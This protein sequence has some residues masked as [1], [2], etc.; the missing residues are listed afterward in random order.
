MIVQIFATLYSECFVSSHTIVDV[1]FGLL[2]IDCR[3]LTVDCWRWHH[4]S[5]SMCLSEH[6]LV[7]QFFTTLLKYFIKQSKHCLA[8]SHRHLVR[9]VRARTNSYFISQ[10]D[11]KSLEDPSEFKDESQQELSDSEG[12]DTPL[13][14]SPQPPLTP[15]PPPQVYAKSNAVKEQIQCKNGLN[16]CKKG[17]K[18]MT[19]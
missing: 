8:L 18:A 6:R 10:D 11:K 4:P 7:C 15:P 5:H 9:S 12:S 16:T 17:N 14:D 3:L 13:C 1:V 19:K 2:T